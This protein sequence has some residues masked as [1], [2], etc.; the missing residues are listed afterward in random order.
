[1]TKKS[2]NKKPK[3]I[4]V[5]DDVI[6]EKTVAKK[7]KKNRRLN[8]IGGTSYV[9][10]DDLSRINTHVSSEIADKEVFASGDKIMVS[11]NFRSSNRNSSPKRG[12]NKNVGMQTSNATAAAANAK[13]MCVIDVMQSPYR[14]IEESPKEIFDVFSDEEND[15]RKKNVPSSN[16]NAN[17]GSTNNI[18][19]QKISKT[20]PTPPNDTSSQHK[21]PSPKPTPEKQQQQL[22]QQQ[23]QQQLQQQQKQQQQLQQ[24]QKQQQLQQQQKQQQQ[25]QQQQQQQ[26]QQTQQLIVQ[27][28]L[29]GGDLIIHTG[30]KGPC[31][32]PPIAE[33]MIDLT[34]G[35]QTPSDP[36]D[37]SY[38]PC[39]PTE[40]PDISWDNQVTLS[41]LRSQR[42]KKSHESLCVR[43]S[44]YK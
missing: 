27:E 21:V 14:I 3:R 9:D 1:M 19:K 12:K 8:V 11:V 15:A 37:D 31:T 20:K 25:L 34:R 33:T 44:F 13:P 29:A 43:I 38:D 26:Q 32:P 6:V 41:G 39:N 7:K 17:V 18:G 16:S 23:K 22:Q 30:H 42:K 2:K 35:P 10:D 5:D 4:G 24:Q 36:P 40:S 28:H